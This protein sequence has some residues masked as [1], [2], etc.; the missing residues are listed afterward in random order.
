MI[1]YSFNVVVKWGFASLECTCNNCEVN[2]V[3]RTCEG[4]L[5]KS[6]TNL[7]INKFQNSPTK[8]VKPSFSILS[9]DQPTTCHLVLISIPCR[10]KVYCRIQSVTTTPS[11]LLVPS[12]MASL[13]RCGRTEGTQNRQHRG[14]AKTLQVQKRKSLA[15]CKIYT[16][17]TNFLD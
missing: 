12:W 13:F 17:P 16:L 6:L 14:N 4:K 2:C 11:L 8:R 3:F 9:V 5:S 10:H 7:L 1:D 15:W